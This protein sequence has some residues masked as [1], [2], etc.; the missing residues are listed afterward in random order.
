MGLRRFYVEKEAMHE[1]VLTIRGDLFHH[2]RDVCRFG[3]GDKFEVLLGDGKAH[4]MELTS[5]GKNEMQARRLSSRELPQLSKPYI[6][7]CLSIPKL[8]KVDW[9]VEK[10][11]E[12][13]AFEIRPFV[14]D[15]SFLRK[16]SEISPSRLARWHKLVQA[17]TQQSGRGD[18]MQV[19]PA[20]RLDKLLGD[21]SRNPSTGGL[22]P[23]EGESQQG[24]SPAL[25]ELKQRNLDHLWVFVGSEGGFSLSEVKQF[26]QAGL[27][28]ISM[29]EQILRVETACL[30]LMSVI[31]YEFGTL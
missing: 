2:I 20:T 4:L 15:Y 14:S 25:E 11:V 5:V 8:P 3:L 7:L 10:C 26:A 31:K 23:Y 12:L 6:T 18:L 13:G 1:E 28:P 17:A 16:E 24:L 9:I 30:A 29:G 19:H 21:F 27:P 22:F